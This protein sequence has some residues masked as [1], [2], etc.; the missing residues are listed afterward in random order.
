M[1]ISQEVQTQV[2]QI[3]TLSDI[4]TS[5][6]AAMAAL[7]TQLSNLQSQVA[8][9]P[10]A[11]PAAQGQPPQ[12]GLSQEDK[13]ALTANIAD[14]AKLI[15]RLKADIVAGTPQAG[16]TVYP[17]GSQGSGGV[18]PVAPNTDPSTVQPPAVVQPEGGTTQPPALQ[19]EPV[20]PT[21]P[22]SGAPGA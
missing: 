11:A 9:V 16:A 3:K 12:P 4:V 22:A 5:V 10:V 6:D 17:A 18:A 14:T 1:T 20:A 2:D 7:K 21:T 8:A 15:D 13:D 19:P